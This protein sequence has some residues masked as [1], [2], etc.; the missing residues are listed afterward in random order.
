MK[1]KLSQI[2][3]C[4]YEDSI[5]KTEVYAIGRDFFMNATYSDGVIFNSWLYYF[6]EYDI[7][8]FTS[9]KEAKEKLKKVFK[10]GKV[11][12]LDKNYWEIRV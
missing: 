1:P 8:W 9:L 7:R 3:Y 5:T 12:Q 4:I 6:N 11:V 2:V 10:G